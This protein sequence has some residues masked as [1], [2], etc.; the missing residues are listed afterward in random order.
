MLTFIIAFF[1][2]GVI[3]A[4]VAFLVRWGDVNSRARTPWEKQKGPAK[5]ECPGCGNLLQIFH[6]DP[7]W[8][9]ALQRAKS[10][11]PKQA[12]S[13]IKRTGRCP[14]CDRPVTEHSKEREHAAPEG[15]VVRRAR[16]KSSG[17]EI[18]GLP[19]FAWVL[20]GLGA[21][22]V[23]LVGVIFII[24][25]V[26]ASQPNA[27]S[28]VPPNMQHAQPNMQPLRLKAQPGPP[29][30]QPAGPKTQ[31]NETPP[32]PPAHEP[33]SATK[34]PGLLAYWSFDEGE[35]ES[36]VDDSGRRMKAKLVNVGRVPGFRGQALSFSGAGSYF[37]YGDS[38]RLSFKE[39]EP[40]TIA[41]WVL[42]RNSKGTLLSHRNSRDGSPVIDILLSGGHL[43]SST[44]P[45]KSTANP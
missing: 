1:G 38:P 29:N 6:N 24:A 31:P 42:T 13:I 4:F 7:R 11:P 20:I 14:V 45:F 32:P 28:P 33:P 8:L 35:G 36:G 5:F 34:L 40:F 23:V 37:D 43:T 15:P 9:E 19:P 21:A 18:L 26:G 41:F 30:V 3:A 10:I 44:F 39:K 25:V 27:T 12:E 2:L 17:A 22:F 16:T